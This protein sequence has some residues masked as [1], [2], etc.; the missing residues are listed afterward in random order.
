MT[1]QNAVFT[2]DGTSQRDFPPNDR[3][4]AILIANAAGQT[5]TASYTALCSGT[6]QRRSDPSPQ[7]QVQIQPASSPSPTP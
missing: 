2:V 3:D 6:E 7:M 1:L 5:L 4:E